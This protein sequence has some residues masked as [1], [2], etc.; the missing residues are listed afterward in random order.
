MRLPA[1]K[2][3]GC[4]AVATG[5]RRARAHQTCRLQLLDHPEASKIFPPDVLERAKLYL[6]KIGSTGAYSESRGAAICRQHI[7]EASAPFHAPC[8][9]DLAHWSMRTT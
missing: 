4:T 1:G 3:P 2:G 6:Q 7:A 8:S 9:C 5:V